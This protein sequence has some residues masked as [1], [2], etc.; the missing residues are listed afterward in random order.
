MLSR[1]SGVEPAPCPCQTLGMRLLTLLFIFLFSSASWAQPFPTNPD[2]NN[3]VNPVNPTNP[4]NTP[5]SRI[6]LITESGVSAIRGLYRG[7]INQTATFIYGGVAGL[8]NVG[9]CAAATSNSTCNNCQANFLSCNPR[10]VHSNLNFSLQFL[11]NFS[12]LNVAGGFPFVQNNAPV[13]S[14]ELRTLQLVN[15]V[16]ILPGNNINVTITL[17]WGDICEKFFG[18]TGSDP[19]S[20]LPDDAP[21]NVILNI[22]VDEEGDSRPDNNLGNAITEVQIFLA[23]LSLDTPTDR[24]ASGD[25][26]TNACNFLA[27]PGDEK[28]FMRDVVTSCAFPQVG[29][30]DITAI[31]VFY[32][33]ANPD[34]DDFPTAVS[35]FA[36]LRIENTG[37]SCATSKTISF[38]EN[39]VPGLAN[40]TTYRFNI[41]LAD[42]AG[43]VGGLINLDP[44]TDTDVSTD[45]GINTGCFNTDPSAPPFNCHVATPSEVIGLLEDELDCFIAT[46]AFGSPFQSKVADFREFR[47]Q[48]LHTTWLGQKV[49]R[50]Y[51]RNSPPLARWM[52]KNP[53]VK[54]IART[55]L[56][57]LWAFAKASLEYPLAVLGLLIALLTGL[58]LRRGRKDFAL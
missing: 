33:P 26:A 29:N 55:L 28:V 45:E 30:A 44:G 16:R 9:G 3:P 50:F 39:E 21:D 47:N 31:R 56:W 20:N 49:I 53:W 23:D 58:F 51:Y 57:P 54:P 34:N 35:P 10:R 7:E 17:N 40:N 38:V 19:C 36:D 8:G 43:N 41:G 22:G 27:F 12:N 52:D 48:Y 5:L 46:A 14:T 1:D 37:A 6:L 13:G 24:C 32:E 2:P 15:P 4:V 18:G 25:T 42:D 11:Y